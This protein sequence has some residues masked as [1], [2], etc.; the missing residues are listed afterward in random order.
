MR[1]K[2]KKRTTSDAREDWEEE[3]LVGTAEFLET[4]R[5]CLSDELDGMIKGQK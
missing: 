3:G 4:G 1:Q 5:E 2:V